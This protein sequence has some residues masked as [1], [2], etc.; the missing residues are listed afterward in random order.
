[1]KAPT[2]SP[3]PSTPAPAVLQV[4]TVLANRLEV[5]FDRL[6]VN[7]CRLAVR[8]SYGVSVDFE[9]DGPKLV[10]VTIRTF[11]APSILRLVC[12]VE[13]LTPDAVDHLACLVGSPGTKP[14]RFWSDRYCGNIWVTDRA[15]AIING[16]SY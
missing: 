16:A 13:D 7:H 6:D 12:V 8:N 9:A 10:Q 4:A 14:S 3:P 2:A 15:H 1:M 11:P 5:P